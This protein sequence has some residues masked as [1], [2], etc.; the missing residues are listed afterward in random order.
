MDFVETDVFGD[1]SLAHP[2]G[3]QADRRTR[4]VDRVFKVDGRGRCGK[5]VK[6]CVQTAFDKIKA[7]LFASPA[8]NKSKLLI[9]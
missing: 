1:E 2:R 4:C 8:L 9:S 7:I 5:I 6:V 3:V